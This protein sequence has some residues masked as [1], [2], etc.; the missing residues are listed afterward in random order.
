MPE[1]QEFTLIRLDD[2]VDVIGGLY[3]RPI[4]DDAPIRQLYFV[5]FNRKPG[6]LVKNDAAVA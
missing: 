1:A 2:H 6:W 5:I 3:P 4:G